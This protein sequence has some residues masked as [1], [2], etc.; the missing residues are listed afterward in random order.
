MTPEQMALAGVLA[1]DPNDHTIRLVLARSLAASSNPVALEHFW[2]LHAAGVLGQDD[3]VL[4]A[5]VALRAGDRNSAQ[6]FLDD[7][8]GGVSEDHSARQTSPADAEG[9]PVAEKLSEGPP[10][11]RA[12][13]YLEGLSD[14]VSFDDIGGLS[15][16]KKAVDQVIFQPI[17]NPELFAKYGKKAGGGVLLYG[18]PGCGKTMVAR[19][20]AHDLV[21]PFYNIR[22]ENILSPYFGDSVRLLGQAFA[23]AR[24]L[25]PCVV[26]IDEL[27]GLGY[28]RSKGNSEV[29]RSIVEGLLLQL[30]SIGSDNE[31]VLVL[32]A[33]NEPWDIDSALI[34]PGRFDRAIFVPPPDGEA[35][36]TILSN[37]LEGTPNEVTD[38]KQ[39]VAST[40]LF[41]GADLVELVGRALSGLLEQI[42]E[43]GSE[44][45][46]DDADLAEAVSVVKPTTLE[47]LNRARNHVDFSNVG[48]RWDDVEAFLKQ[49]HVARTI[50]KADAED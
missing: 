16:V 13:N 11:Y 27:D 50:R 43:T 39:L 45:P 38:L 42:V 10:K 25:S 2:A 14:E 47:W 24:E 22:L 34:R 23:S 31:G 48:G 12:E 29:G 30:D 8:A 21:L 46:L 6:R 18:P 35:R 5:E 36:Q 20:I 17:R 28:A 1:S 33:S 7:D 4:A 32:A 15:N 44:R 3:Q 49:R 19:A 26:F 9:G 37:R 41:S 40:E